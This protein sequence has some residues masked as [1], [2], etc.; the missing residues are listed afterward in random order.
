LTWA[1][2]ANLIMVLMLGVVAMNDGYYFEVRLGKV[3]D[4]RN[5][6]KCDGL[7]ESDQFTYDGAVRQETNEGNEKSSKNLL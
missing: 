6:A 3:T 2:K 1:F 7:K 5:W 4:G